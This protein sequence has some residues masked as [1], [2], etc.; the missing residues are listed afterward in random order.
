MAHVDKSLPKSEA[1]SPARSHG[2]S[3]EDSAHVNKTPS[4]TTPSDVY[5][6]HVDD[7]R[8]TQ[9]LA[10]QSDEKFSS[11][12]N[13]VNFDASRSEPVMGQVSR[14]PCVAEDSGFDVSSSKLVL[15]RALKVSRTLLWC[16]DGVFEEVNQDQGSSVECYSSYLEPESESLSRNPT[17]FP[18]Y[19]NMP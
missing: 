18:F 9:R 13:E 4:P 19:Y 12:I 1:P 6:T 3:R 15:P 10:V 14:I 7:V 8:E 2:Q 16:N 11:A 5:T 17:P